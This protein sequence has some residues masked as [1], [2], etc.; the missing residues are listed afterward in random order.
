MV[1]PNHNAIIFFLVRTCQ[2]HA[3]IN[4]HLR[5]TKGGYASLLQVTSPD[6]LNN[7]WADKKKLSSV[8]HVES[9]LE[10]VPSHV[11]IVTLHDAH[12]A[13]LSWLGSVNGNRVRGLGVTSFGQSGDLPDT[14]RFY[15][16][17]ANSVYEAALEELEKS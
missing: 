7:D 16:I 1:G 6:R 12:P 8:P 5:N 3:R 2:A 11:P 17:D 4:E 13:A 14:H 15:N 10:N 9:L